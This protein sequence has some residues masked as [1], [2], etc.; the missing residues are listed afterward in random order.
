VARARH[1]TVSVTPTTYHFGDTVTVHYTDDGPPGVATGNIQVRCWQ[2]NKLVYW[3]VDLSF[4]DSSGSRSFVLSSPSGSLTN[5]Y[6]VLWDGGPATGSA[7]FV[8]LFFKDG[9][10]VRTSVIASTPFSVE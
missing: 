6:P 3:A 2:G 8:K 9:V 7:E 1:Q 10:V 4:L 5:A